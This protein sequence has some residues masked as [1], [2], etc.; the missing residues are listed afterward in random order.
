[1]IDERWFTVLYSHG[2]ITLVAA[3]DFIYLVAEITLV[4]AVWADW[5]KSDL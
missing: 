3:H 2:E 5:M 1:M 4:D